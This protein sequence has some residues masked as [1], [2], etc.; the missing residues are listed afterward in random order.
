MGYKQAS[1]SKCHFCTKPAKTRGMCKAHYRA[2][3]KA[4]TH[5]QFAKL[6]PEDVFHER[7]KVAPSGCWEWTASRSSSFGYGLLILPGEKS[8]RAHRYSYERTN[9]PIP[10]GKV[11]MHTCDNPPCVNPAHLILGTRLENNRDAASKGR[12][13]QKVR[14]DQ[15]DEIRNLAKTNT[16]RVVGDIFGIS[17]THVMRICRRKLSSDRL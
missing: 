7:Y 14:L 9:G 6:G 1:R 13:Q 10:D 4:G 12:M 2:H 16:L 8:V 15:F 5:L 3:H 11:I 17:A